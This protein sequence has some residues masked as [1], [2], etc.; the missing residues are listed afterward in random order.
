[1]TA[2]KFM[3]KDD[4]DIEICAETRDVN[5]VLPALAALLNRSGGISG[6]STDEVREA[7][8]AWKKA[9]LQGGPNAPVED[10]P[11]ANG[12]N[13][14]PLNA[15][16][17]KWWAEQAKVEDGT[18][19]SA[20]A[21]EFT[22]TDLAKVVLNHEA[23]EV[24]IVSMPTEEGSGTRSDRRTVHRTSPRRLHGLRTHHRAIV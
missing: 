11:N 9:V 18:S 4:D 12:F 14:Q 22:T 17:M 5:P 8:R 6:P 16:V 3:D 19:M 24:V 7:I 21:V 2:L 1:V 13:E 15:A 10:L 20:M 23:A